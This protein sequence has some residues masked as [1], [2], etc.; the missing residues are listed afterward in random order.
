MGLS[1]IIERSLSW[2]SEVEGGLFWVRIEPVRL[3]LERRKGPLDVV[4]GGSLIVRR[5]RRGDSRVES[6]PVVV[7][8]DSPSNVATFVCEWQCNYLPLF[9]P[10]RDIMLLL[11]T[12]AR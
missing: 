10:N 7:A 2:Y 1:S 8:G 6:S 5:S 3:R 11:Q 12:P 9:G 4:I